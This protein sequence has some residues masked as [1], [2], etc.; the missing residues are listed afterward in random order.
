MCSIGAVDKEQLALMKEV[1]A[2]LVMKEYVPH[3]KLRKALGSE[4]MAQVFERAYTREDMLS[5]IKFKLYISPGTPWMMG[6]DEKGRFAAI[7]RVG[8]AALMDSHNV[9]RGAT[10]SQSLVM[11]TFRKFVESQEK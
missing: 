4:E 7:Q 6:I 10:M 5:A 3:Y 8:S 11:I 2:A 9:H 1:L